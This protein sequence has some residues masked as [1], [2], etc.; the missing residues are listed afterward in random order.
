MN[1]GR[2]LT[3]SLS[4]CDAAVSRHLCLIESAKDIDKFLDGSVLVT[5]ATDPDWVPIMKRAAA[6]VGTGNSTYV[7]Y[8]SQGVTVSC[9]VGDN[10]F[11]YEGISTIST[12]TVDLAGLREVKTKV[13][14]NLANPAS[15][16]RWWRLPEDGIG[17]ARMEFVV[18]NAVQVHPAVLVH[19]DRLKDQKAKED[20]SQLTT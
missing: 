10:G 1:K 6:I 20:V 2:I 19:Y 17:L 13:M 9:A 7:L 15:A 8:T 4:V 3:I 11:V 14:L 16:Y 18:T 5:E 12:H